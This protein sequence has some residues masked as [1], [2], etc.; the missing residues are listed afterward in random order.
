ML[1]QSANRTN[2]VSFSGLYAFPNNIRQLPKISMSL[3][4]HLL[5][6]GLAPAHAAFSFNSS[7]KMATEAKQP[8]IDGKNNHEGGEEQAG[9]YIFL[10]IYIG[11]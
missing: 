10:Q 4:G 7:W 9:K 8:K 11:F 6:S 3:G 5:T 2:L 1:S